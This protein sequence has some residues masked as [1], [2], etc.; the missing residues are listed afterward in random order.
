[1]QELVVVVQ[2][3]VLFLYGFDAV[4]D[5]E[6]GELKGFC[7]SG[8]SALVLWSSCSIWEKGWVVSRV[9]VWGKE[10]TRSIAPW[11]PPTSSRGLVN[12]AAGSWLG[13]R[14][15]RRFLSPL[16]ARR[17]GVR[18]ARLLCQRICEQQLVGGGGRC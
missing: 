16:V 13:R 10:H 1:L 15:R 6:E 5:L 11:H 17:V 18:G 12:S 8:R 3:V 2:L 9:W 4:E 7:V 14:P